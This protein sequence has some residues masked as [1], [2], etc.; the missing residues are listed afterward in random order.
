MRS[1]AVISLLCV[2]SICAG[3]VRAQIRILPK[4]VLDAVD[5]PRLSKDSSSLA[6]STR[7][8]DAE[9]MKESDSPAAFRVEME[10]VGMSPVEISGIRTSCSCVTAM[11]G[12]NSLPPG[13]KTFLTVRYD[14]K[15]HL[16]RFE[17]KVFIYTL[18][19]NA[20]SAI[21]N[22]AVQ[23]E[24]GSDK[25]GLYHVQMGRIRL[26]TSEIMFRVGERAVETLNF[27]NLSG[28]P[29]ELECEEVFL[30]EYL[31]FETRPKVVRDG[32]E[33]TIV[34]TYEPSGEEPMSSVPMILKDLGV[35]PG[36][37]TIKIRFE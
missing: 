7:H 5:S 3:N 29:L 10:N 14:P 9:P 34:I 12:Q 15:G 19:G 27:I 31:R 32:E 8:I 2:L 25:S 21:I 26:R 35:S 1:L 23:V 33:G 30:P 20:P 17:H 11:A 22:L 13:G 16:G 18:P 24:S 36:R 37:S 28:R 6:L 4:A